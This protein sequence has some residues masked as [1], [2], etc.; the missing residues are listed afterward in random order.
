MSNTQLQNIA[1]HKLDHGEGERLH[2]LSS[3]M[4]LFKPIDD[5]LCIMMVKR[6]E[7]GV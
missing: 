5:N 3:Q 7:K 4:R 2:I 1:I 6:L